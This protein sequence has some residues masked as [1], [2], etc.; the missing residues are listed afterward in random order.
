MIKSGSFRNLS[1]DRL[2]EERTGPKKAGSNPAMDI[3]GRKFKLSNIKWLFAIFIFFAISSCVYD[4]EFAYLNDQIMT[5]NKRIKT[6]EAKLGGSLD[7]RL[8]TI[9]S[10]IA[11]MS[12][13]T[14]RLKTGIEVLSGRVEDNEHIIKRT[15]ERD[16]HQQDKIQMTL[17]DLS[18]RVPELE[19]VVRQQHKYL[20]LEP[21]ALKEDQKPEE[22]TAVSDEPKSTEVAAYEKSLAS[23]K[24][25]KFEMAMVGFKTFLKNFPKSD[26]ADNGQFWIGECYMNLRQFEQAILAYQEVIKKYP[27][28]NK[29][30]NA[31]LRQAVAFLEIKDKTSSRLLL[32]KIVKKYPRS[33]EAKIAK[34]K[35]LLLK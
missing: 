16:L 33:N 21:S 34:K 8:E 13:E 29:V 11:E 9:S 6:I 3:A 19:A 22:G 2:I 31:L 25:E 26:R 20:G 35:L 24:E 15:V 14:D 12:V 5:L 23:F 17:A 32:K 7:S 30:P 4:R 1:L 27:K 28:G 18:R 10:N